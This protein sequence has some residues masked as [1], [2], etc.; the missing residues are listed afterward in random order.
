[1]KNG[2]NII[3]YAA[4]EFR[5]FLD[6]PPN[7]VDYAI[8]ALLS[9]FDFSVFL[10][11]YGDSISFSDMYDLSKKDAFLKRVSYTENDDLLFSSVF[12]NPRFK[13][14]IALRYEHFFFPA[15]EEQFAAISFYLPTGEEVIAFRG[16]DAS[17]IGWK[18]DFNLCSDTPLESQIDAAKYLRKELHYSNKSLSLVGHSK[19]GNL[20]SYCYF[21]SSE[22]ERKRIRSVYSFDG[23]GFSNEMRKLLHPVN[24]EKY[25]HLVPEESIIGQLYN[26][27]TFSISIQSDAHHI[28][29]HSLYRWLVDENSFL[30][31]R[32][33]NP[34]Y[35]KWMVSFN[36]WAKK[37][38]LEDRHFLVNTIY[39]CIVSSKIKNAKE[40]R[41]S[42]PS[43]LLRI[44]KEIK[45]LPEE[46]VERLRKI[47]DAF[48]YVLKVLFFPK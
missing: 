34:S 48:P 29:Q 23:P 11:L 3:D 47:C 25:F 38:P 6:F 17:L 5:S 22:T 8:F 14:V 44:R 20:A 21:S 33:I 35:K 26:E 2:R 12:G 46:Q 43:S 19:G 39:E 13:H 36:E 31:A 45:R 30:R 40:L 28:Y 27:S 10:P 32:F 37:T 42:L 41:E 4:N 15:S 18:E 24:D 9:Y 16:T 1:M 7:E